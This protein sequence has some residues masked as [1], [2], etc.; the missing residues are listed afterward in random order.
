[1][2]P[3][4]FLQ[5]GQATRI[6]PE[7]ISFEEFTGGSDFRVV[8]PETDEEKLSFAQ[9]FGEDL[10]KRRGIAEEI[11]D[12]VTSGEQTFA[13]GVLQVA[14]KVGIGGTFDLI[15]QGLVSGFRALPDQVED[16]IRNAGTAFLETSVGSAGLR[17]LKRG[18]DSYNKW[19]EKNRRA[20]R[21]LEAVVDVGLMFGPIRPA[22]TKPTV[23]GTVGE[24]AL[25]SGRAAAE[26]KRA[27]FIDDLI[28]PKQTAAVRGEQT[29]R[30]AETGR[31]I[32]RKKIVE[33]S[34]VERRIAKE[35][36]D[37][38]GV[39]AGRTL[40]GNLNSIRQRNT[41]LAR[42]LANDLKKENFVFPKKELAAQLDDALVRIRQNPTI[43]G[44]AERTATKLVDEFNRRL[45]AAKATGADLLQVRKDFDA[46]VKSQKGAKVFDPK[47]ENA[48]TVSLREIRQTVNNFLEKKAPKTAVRESLK[49]QNNLFRAIENITPKA[50]DEASSAILRAWQRTSQVLTV[51]STLVQSLA[52]AAGIGGLGAA[53]IFAPFVR[54]IVLGF[55]LVA[56]TRGL[57][58][59]PKTRIF[60]GTLLKAI[61]QAIKKT[62]NRQ[63]IEQL[64]ADRAF[65]LEMLE[66][67]EESTDSAGESEPD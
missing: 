63:L 43:V 11:S 31:G 65:I 59:S 30:T 36:V 17:S 53:A 8:E 50:A 25:T 29:A 64:R 48:L 40:Q 2:N 60:L 54:N 38:E 13:E 33:P 10:E 57:I 58:M 15:G 5:G 55:G 23:T 12:A 16:P 51:K 7:S 46:W 4:D 19:K 14:G 42:A 27:D 41:E 18:L 47:N 37:I 35:V 20:A 28:R 21:N 61:D 44:D 67:A 6:K 34:A 62:T 39:A 56:G 66:T 45:A 9:R 26:A 1:M 49:K 32:F 52:F 24:R 3:E 22:P